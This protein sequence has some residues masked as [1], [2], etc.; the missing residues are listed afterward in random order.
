[1]QHDGSKEWKSVDVD[2]LGT[3]LM[4]KAEVPEETRGWMGTEVD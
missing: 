4:N 2:G 3:D 1:M